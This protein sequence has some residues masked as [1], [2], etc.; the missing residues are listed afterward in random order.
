[1]REIADGKDAAV[2]STIEDAG[3]LDT[4]RPALLDTPPG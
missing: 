2:P 3:V 1:M 4:L